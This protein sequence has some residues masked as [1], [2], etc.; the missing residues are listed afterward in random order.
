MT[1]YLIT[2]ACAF[3]VFLMFHLHAF[4]V[5]EL[6]LLD[7]RFRI[8]PN[9][10][11]SDNIVLIDI[12]QDSID[13]IGRWPWNR[14]WHA[15]LITALDVFDV[16]AIFY[17]VIFSEPTADSGDGALGKAIS[18]S[19]NVYIPFAF[20][21][22]GIDSR[23]LI[24]EDHIYGI[25]N[26]IDILK[27]SARGTGFINML[28]DADGKLRRVPLV[29]NYKNK[30]YMQAAF[31]LAC[32]ILGVNEKDVII[33]K[34]KCVR[35]PVTQNKNK[36]YIDIPIDEN[37]QMLIN[38]PGFWKDSFRH[39][40]FYDTIKSFSMVNNNEKPIIPV[41][42]FNNAICIIGMAVSGLIDIKPTPIEPL[43]PAAGINACVLD[44][45]LRSDF[46]RKISNMLDVIL[47]IVMAFFMAY[48]FSANYP[49]R[50]LLILLAIL[51]CYI[52]ITIMLFSMFSIWVN[53]IY[54]VIAV[55]ITYIAL[56]AYNELKIMTEKKRFFNLAITDGLT[57]LYQKSHFNTLMETAFTDRRMHKGRGELSVILADIDYFKKIN[58]TY[59]HLFGDFVLRETAKTVRLTCRP[60]DI[61]GRYG[62]EEFIIMLPNTALK[63]AMVIA[64]RI[65]E[66]VARKVFRHMKKSCKITVS[67][68]VANLKR[69]DS[70]QIFI[71]RADTA[72]YKAKAH[73]R[74]RVYGSNI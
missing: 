54:S 41:E 20:N 66:A 33:K 72:L 59:G 64:E 5:F 44:N 32:D 39:L 15:A 37:Y 11:I 53:I 63:E 38:W 57:G 24:S 9:L 42:N 13:N 28:P 58:D 68:G 47:I 35:L 7:A 51:C 52:F 29:I 22:E 56:T 6:T 12:S 30:Y 69:K 65:R 67:L 62:G 60:L 16:K 18:A 34:G 50:N 14:K 40:S 10:T 31:K 49:I 19:G 25:D 3:V 70:Q 73:G 21:I 1:K 26:S 23:A 45:I 46:C 8:R 74:N 17:D 36:Y 71:H 48:L 43:Y 27:S 2:F 55:L 61:C 4:D